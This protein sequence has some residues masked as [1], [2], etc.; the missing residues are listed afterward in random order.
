MVKA[1]NKV[2]H[3]Y[4]AIMGVWAASEVSAGADEEF[5]LGINDLRD[6]QK[7]THAKHGELVGLFAVRHI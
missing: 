6:R 5:F 2:T 1:E 4:W 7:V 3:S